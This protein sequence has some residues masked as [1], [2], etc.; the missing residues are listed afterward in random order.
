MGKNY[1]EIK[2]WKYLSGPYWWTGEDAL[3][4]RRAK[5]GA[6]WV[7]HFTDLLDA[8]GEDFKDTP[9]EC[10]VKR[11][12]FDELPHEELVAALHS[13][14]FKLAAN[15]QNE[16]SVYNGYDNELVA[17]GDGVEPTCLQCC[18]SYGLGAPLAEVSGKRWLNVRGQARREAE[19][20]LRDEHRT[21]EALDRPVNRIGSTAREMGVGDIMSALARDRPGTDPPAM[22]LMRRLHG[23]DQGVA[24]DE[25]AVTFRVLHPSGELTN[26]RRIKHSALRACPFSILVA[27]HYREDGTC[28]CDDE[29]HRATVMKKWGYKKKHFAKIPLRL[30]K[31]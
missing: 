9:Y 26:V 20:L 2:G 1:T 19:S 15:E 6:W 24:A 30:K 31:E 23:M 17:K 18:I 11:L 27:E 25:G 16:I 5:D 7:L 8:G 29:E 28:K 22:Q 14:G 13:C 21:K 3:W 10:A 4:G 12:S